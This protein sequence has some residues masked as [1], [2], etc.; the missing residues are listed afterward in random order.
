MDIDS[1]A[2]SLTVGADIIAKSAQLSAKDANHPHTDALVRQMLQTGSELVASCVALAH[3]PH[4]LA[5]NI[6]LR[7][8]IEVGI[9]M[10]WSTMSSDNAELLR[11]T[12]KDQIKTM[13]RLNVERGIAKIMDSAGD[14]HTASFLASGRLDKGTRPPSIEAMA[15]QCDLLD[16][17]NVFYRFQSLHT[18]ANDV[19]G[20]SSQTNVA[21]L[22]AVGAFSKLIG[23]VG[24]RWLLA[25]SRPDNEEIRELLGLETTATLRGSTGA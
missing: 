23:H 5:V 14:D 8:L 19:R 21:A 15:R 16:L 2:K 24:A 20:E 22:G 11:N 13:V 10:H 6:L 3:G 17:Y 1:I 7:S 25:R 18:H 4:A 9:K 12:T